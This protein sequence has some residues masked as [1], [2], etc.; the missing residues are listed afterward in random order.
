MAL[1]ER[2]V[3]IQ[4]KI[5]EPFGH[6][7]GEAFAL[8]N[9][10]MPEGL[11]ALEEPL[12]YD[13]P[14]LRETADSLLREVR[15]L[16]RPKAGALLSPVAPGKGAGGLLIGRE[17]MKSP[18]LSKN[19]ENLGRVFPF[20]ATEGRE[21]AA[22]AATLPNS[23]KLPAFLVRYLALKTA[24]REIERTIGERFKT[25][26][27]AAM[28]P[29]ALKE[30]PIEAQSKLFRILG[31]LPKLLGVALSPHNWMSPEVSSSGLFFE[32]EGGFHNCRYCLMDS[33]PLRRYPRE[34][35]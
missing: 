28:S 12:P 21:I 8:E 24:E 32:T 23:L 33:C 22:W 25:G 10:A 14:K 13:S 5:P 19:L 31:R 1:G 34:G 2:P 20:L 18:I 6:G 29:G 7:P 35:L 11:A 4:E 27:L 16:A 15:T 9:I 3:P 17:A 30:W 26:T